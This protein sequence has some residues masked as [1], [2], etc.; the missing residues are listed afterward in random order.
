MKFVTAFL[1]LSL[2]GFFLAPS[3]YAA[4]IDGNSVR[5]PGFEGIN[6]SAGQ[7]PGFRTADFWSSSSQLAARAFVN[8]DGINTGSNGYMW[9]VS[10]DENR[11]QTG[12]NFTGT[13]ESDTLYTFSATAY[14]TPNAQ[15]GLADYAVTMSLLE[16]GRSASV[17]GS[18]VDHAQ[19]ILLDSDTIT[20]SQLGGTAPLSINYLDDGTGLDLRLRIQFDSAAV[21]STGMLTRGG[22]DDV[23]LATSIVPEPSSLLLACG[24]L[25]SLVSWQRRQLA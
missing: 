3:T 8:Q 6:S 18:I 21:L 24:G 25:M 23:M 9:I 11:G 17:G 10:E 4:V 16:V 15:P 7:R 2:V 5:N 20:I 13:T 1:C 14:N 19:P 12:Q 22:V